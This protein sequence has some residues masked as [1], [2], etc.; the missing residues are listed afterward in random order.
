M[1]AKRRAKNGAA[2]FDDVMLRLEPGD[3]MRFPLA[4]DFAKAD[5]G[6]H[7]VL[8]AAHGSWPSP[9]LA[10]HPDRS[11]PP[12]DRDGCAAATAGDTGSRSA[13]V[14]RCRIADCASSTNL[15]GDVEGGV[16]GAFGQRW[17]G[18]RREQ[19][20]LVALTRPRH[21]GRAHIVQHQ[22]PRGFAPAFEI[23]FAVEGDEVHLNYPSSLAVRR[24]V[25]AQVECSRDRMT[26]VAQNPNPSCAAFGLNRSASRAPSS[27]CGEGR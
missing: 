18:D 4:A 22:R 8:V 19:F 9:Q 13:A 25:S 12:A 20:R 1:S 16:A 5:K 24:S 17:C 7:L 26:V 3:V 2:S 21:V 11:R 10:R 23:G 27:R 15:A 14:S 6:M